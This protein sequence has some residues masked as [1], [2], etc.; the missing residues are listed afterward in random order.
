MRLQEN[1][2]IY[3]VYTR[4][5]F[6]QLGDQCHLKSESA[7]VIVHFLLTDF[8]AKLGYLC[9]P[10]GNSCANKQA[11]CRQHGNRSVCLCDWGYT[12]EGNVCVFNGKSIEP[13]LK[14]IVG[15]KMLNIPFLYFCTSFAFGRLSACLCALVQLLLS[16]PLDMVF[17]VKYYNAL[18]VIS[19][20]IHCMCCSFFYKIYNQVCTFL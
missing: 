7:F 1:Q 15:L 2:I 19:Q 13:H 10:L 17:Q 18:D 4:L 9:Q 14:F 20:V 16:M 11:V 12:K 6:T 5:C 8:S 3:V